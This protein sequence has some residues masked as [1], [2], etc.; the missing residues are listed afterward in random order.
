MNEPGRERIIRRHVLGSIPRCHACQHLYAADAVEVISRED[1]FWLM[2]LTCHHCRARGFVATLLRGADRATASVDVAE[3]EAR[4]RADVGPVSVDDVAT[5]RER[6]N[7][8]DGSLNDLFSART[9]RN[10]D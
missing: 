4:R 10:G 6:L 2:L 3:P 1:D 7:R 5:V 8:F 9:S